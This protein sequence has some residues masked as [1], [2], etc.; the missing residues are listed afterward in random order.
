MNLLPAG[1]RIEA[2]VCLFSIFKF[3]FASFLASL[4]DDGV[5]TLPSQNV[6]PFLIVA[7]T[8]VPISTGA[9][10]WVESICPASLNPPSYRSIVLFCRLF[11]I[12]KAGFAF[13]RFDLDNQCP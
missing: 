10:T 2:H 13:W 7:M 1:Q 11:I 6:L 4:E 3:H 8:D 5:K 12:S 9:H